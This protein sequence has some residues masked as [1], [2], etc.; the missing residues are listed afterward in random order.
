MPLTR[1]ENKTQKEIFG[2]KNLKKTYKT[3]E[4]NKP[5]AR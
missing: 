1:D 4:N 5:Q 3:D 2:K